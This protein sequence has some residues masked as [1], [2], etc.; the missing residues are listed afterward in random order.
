SGNHRH[1]CAGGKEQHRN[2]DNATVTEA[3]QGMDAMEGKTSRPIRVKPGPNHP[4]GRPNSVTATAGHRD[5]YASGLNRITGCSQPCHR[6]PRPLGL[7]YGYSFL[8][9]LLQPL[10]FPFLKL[11]QSNFILSAEFRP[12]GASGNRLLWQKYTLLK[13][14]GTTPPRCRLHK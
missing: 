6:D 4:T 12:L 9:M 7:R 11:L 3:Q 14:C 1:D 2:H 5:L 8:L 10:R 13:P